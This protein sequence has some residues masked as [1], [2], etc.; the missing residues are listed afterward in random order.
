[1]IERT[2]C[3]SVIILVFPPTVKIVSSQIRYKKICICC[4]LVV[5]IPFFNPFYDVLSI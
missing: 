4:Y 5:M 2:Y 1:M 3:H